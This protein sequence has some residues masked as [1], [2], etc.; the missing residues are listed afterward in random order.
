[1]IR[2]YMPNALIS[3]G[4]EVAKKHPLDGTVSDPLTA[5]ELKALIRLILHT[6]TVRLASF[7]E[8]LTKREISALCDYIPKATER[9]VINKVAQVLTMIMKP[10]LY[11]GLLLSWQQFPANRDL[12]KLLAENAA[13]GNEVKGNTID[14]SRFETWYTLS[15][16]LTAYLSDVTRYIFG[17]TKTRS[18]LAAAFE[19]AGLKMNSAL[20]SC[21]LAQYMTECT[22]EELIRYDDFGIDQCI[23]NGIVPEM[24]N[25]II[26]NL[27]H[28]RQSDRK[29]LLSFQLCYRTIY[30]KYG[31]P[32]RNKFGAN[33]QQEYSNYLWWYNYKALEEG[34]NHDADRRRINFWSNYMDRCNI[35]RL[36]SQQFIIMDFGGYCAVESET[37]GTLYFFKKAYFNETVHR[38]LR[39]HTAQE[40]KSWMKNYSDYAYN[41]THRG[42]WEGEVPVMMRRFGMI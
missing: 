8:T 6:P 10:S 24:R 32:Q 31:I 5:E 40:G 1:M 27:L 23:R 33:N 14:V 34:F 9:A 35:M 41:K 37:I 19:K 7:A 18:N 38:Y 22:F 17:L 39:S 21:C 4:L 11:S 28:C 26:L 12:L 16:H 25:G 2:T 42:R 30:N 29:K 3:A 20:Y 15:D 36:K 13:V